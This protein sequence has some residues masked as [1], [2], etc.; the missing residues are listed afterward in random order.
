MPFPPGT[1]TITLTGTVLSAASGTPHMGRITLTPSARLVDASRNAVYHGGGTVTLD[2]NGAFS[3]TL[4]PCD[5]AGVQPTGWQWLISVEPNSAPRQY[6]RASLTGTGTIDLSD[7]MP[8]DAPNGGS[9]GSNQFLVRSANLTD[10][11]DPAAAR[12]AL[13]LGTAATRDVGLLNMQV[14]NGEAVGLSTG[15]VSGGEM[16]IN[17][18]NPLAVDFSAT[19]GYI[20]D[21]VTTPATPT[22]TRV[23]APA[24]TVVLADLVSPITWWSMTSAGAIVQQT[25]RPTNTQRRTQLQLGATVQAGGV[26]I[27]AEQTLPVILAQPVQQLYDLMYALGAFSIEGNAIGPNGSNLTFSKTA[28]TVFAPS[29]NR[30]AGPTLTN[31]PHVSSTA[32][33]APAQFRYVFRNTNPVPPPIT[34]LDPANY[35]V[36]GV[37]TPVGG[38]SGRATVQRVY[39]FASNATPDQLVVQYGQNVYNSLGEAVAAVGTETFTTNPTAAANGVLLGFICMTRTATDLSDTAQ[40]RFIPAGKFGASAGGSGTSSS[41]IRSASIRI[42][43]GTISDLPSAPSWAIAQTSV[44]T[45]LKCSITAAAGDRIRCLG[46]FMYD[47]AHFMDY[48]LLTGAGALGT[49]AASG[50]TSPLAEGNPTLYPSGAFAKYTSAEFFTAGA[51]HIDGTGKVTVALAHQGTNPGKVYAHTLYPWRL[52]LENIGPEPA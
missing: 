2:A 36:G 22:V 30:Y 34:T 46:L 41:S 51:E 45:Q 10:L 7:V 5:A 26:M 28:G 47:G 6:Y 40:A 38:G 14:A 21:Y 31:D 15:I 11:T 35:D 37:L 25:T 48:N 12:T 8:V 44:G 17:A 16:N 33:Q 19:V 50:T 4:L 39:L 43:D 29:F 27:I 20:V 1:P 52:R 42:T 24:Q 32:A 23:S 9:T 49:Y 3:I 18:G 13:G